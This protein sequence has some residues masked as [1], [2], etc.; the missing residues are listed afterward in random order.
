MVSSG[1]KAVDR[2][3][4]GNLGDSPLRRR[5]QKTPRMEIGTSG[6][7]RDRIGLHAS[8]DLSVQPR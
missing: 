5:R 2:R 3:L 8:H 1:S 7:E 4:P 6:E